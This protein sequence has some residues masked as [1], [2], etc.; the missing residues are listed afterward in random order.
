MPEIEDEPVHNVPVQLVPDT[1]DLS[2]HVVFHLHVRRTRAPRTIA[3][4][5]A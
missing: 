3:E 5:V 1:L 2:E 4:S